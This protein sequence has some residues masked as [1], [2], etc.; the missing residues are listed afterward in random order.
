MNIND[1][2]ILN[3]LDSL[4]NIPDDLDYSTVED[5]ECNYTII[6]FFS[7]R[8]RKHK[9]QFTIFIDNLGISIEF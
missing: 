2:S 4:H 3:I 9:K 6:L 8:I 5:D 1:D 7:S